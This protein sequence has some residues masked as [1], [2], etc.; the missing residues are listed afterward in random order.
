MAINEMKLIEGLL[1]GSLIFLVGFLVCMAFIYFYIQISE[2]PLGIQDYEVSEYNIKAPSDWI[3]EDQIQI[4]DDKIVIKVDNPSL[5][6]YT[7]TGSMK[8]VLD[9][10]A[11]GVRIVP[12]SADQIRVGDIVSFKRGK[13]LIVHRVV[14]KAYDES[15]IYFIT[16]GDNN[17]VDD[18]K[19]R[20]KDIKYVTVA[21]IW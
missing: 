5:S 13:D 20:F 7:P 12:E 6:K 1:K 15:G 16:K 9:Y 2:K 18:G 19:V 3:K 21:L 8:P 11:N 17:G 14:E 10:G 4:Y